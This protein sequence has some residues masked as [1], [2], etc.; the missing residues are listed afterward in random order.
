MLDRRADCVCVCVISLVVVDGVEQFCRRR[1]R[2]R[3]KAIKSAIDRLL[4]RLAG[5]QPYASANGNA[6]WI[7]SSGCGGRARR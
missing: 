5:E 2:R 3:L 7:Q 6:Q 1:R 4:R